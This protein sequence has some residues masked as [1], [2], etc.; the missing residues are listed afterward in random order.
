MDTFLEWCNRKGLVV[1]GFQPAPEFAQAKRWEQV[2]ELFHKY[3]NA[4][5]QFKT[6]KGQIMKGKMID[7][8]GEG[9]YIIKTEDGREWD[10]EPFQIIAA[11]GARPS[12]DDPAYREKRYQRVMNRPLSPQQQ[13]SRMQRQTFRGYGY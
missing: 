4:W 10:V 1:E 7:V 11:S 9:V 3:R 12:F 8:L 5:V 2:E 13:A 6:D